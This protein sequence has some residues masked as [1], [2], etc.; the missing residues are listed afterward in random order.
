MD[1]LK[2]VTKATDNLKRQINQIKHNNPR[3]E[4]LYKNSLPKKSSIK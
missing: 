4:M 3:N 2:N 1:E